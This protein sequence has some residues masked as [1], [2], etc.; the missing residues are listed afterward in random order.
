MQKNVKEFRMKHKESTFP[1]LYTWREFC[2][3]MLVAIVVI[4]FTGCS[5]LAIVRSAVDIKGQEVA[6]R[7]LADAEF[8][9]CRGV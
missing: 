2:F 1:L 5:Q 7:A 9:M 4:L 6:D 3:A 8:V